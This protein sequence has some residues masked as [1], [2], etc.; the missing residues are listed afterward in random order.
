MENAEQHEV[1]DSQETP[2]VEKQEVD[3]EKLMSRV[4]QLEGSYNR[5]LDESKNWKS[6][7]KGLRD[8]VEQSEVKKLEE[9]ESH[10][11]LLEIERNNSHE[12][13]Q[14]LS[15]FKKETLKQKIQFETA[16]HA[17]NAFDVNDVI[18]NLPKEM[19]SIDEDNLTVKGVGEAIGLVKEK[20][21]WLFDDNKSHGM[22]QKRPV[23]ESGRST[24]EDLSKSEKDD[25]F[26]QALNELHG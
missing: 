22:A 21:P 12:L 18:N 5:V 25:L 24:Y 15:H 19:L 6:K 2:K 7:Y 9:S 3:V 20:K 4:D 13:R 17:P 23:G 14:Q 10:K 11:E 8:Q 26:T 1:K 16:K